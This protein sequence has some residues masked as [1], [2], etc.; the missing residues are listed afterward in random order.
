MK[1][2]Q[3]WKCTVALAAALLVGACAVGTPF[4][5]PAA[6]DIQLGKTTYDE[7]VARLGNPE[8]ETRTRMNERV[9][10]SISYTYIGE[11]ESPKAANSMGGRELSYLILDN[12]VVAES[13]MSSYASD[14]TDFDER[15]YQDIVKGKTRCE[16]V[17]AMYGRP[18]IRAIYP[19]SDKPGDTIIGYT[20]RYMKRPLLQFKMFKK[21]LAVVCDSQG[22]A[23][24]VA[25]SESGDR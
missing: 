11:A 1:T 9:M 2:P 16:E 25:Y 21:T 22:V 5:R 13:F 14:H 24:D 10:R 15:R 4:V 6:D 18:C 3:G 23:S 12:V 20:F 19:V 8:G 17:V 7:L